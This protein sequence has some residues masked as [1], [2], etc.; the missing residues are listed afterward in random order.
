MIVQQFYLKSLGHA[1]YLI[2]SEA[3]GEALVLDVRR[4]V[5]TYFEAARAQELRIAYAFD[6]HQHND[7]L[8]GLCELPVR[9]EVQLLASAR[10]ELDYPTRPDGRS[11]L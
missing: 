11:G 4:D 8:T 10:A 5:E 9:G 3:T 6:T 1:S 7:D 2:G